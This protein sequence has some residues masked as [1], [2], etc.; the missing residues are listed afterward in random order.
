M[1]KM[2]EIK[3]NEVK[4]IGDIFPALIHYNSNNLIA[5]LIR[6][7]FK[8]NG[9]IAGGF[10]LQLAKLLKPKAGDLELHVHNV[11]CVNGQNHMTRYFGRTYDHTNNSIFANASSGDI[12]LWFPDKQSLASFE[13]SDELKELL[14]LRYE[15]QPKTFHTKLTSTG[16]AKQYAIDHSIRVQVITAYLLPKIEQ[17]SRFDIYNS[18]CAFDGTTLTYPEHLMDLEDRRML[19]VSNWRSQNS[20]YKSSWTVNRVLKYMNPRHGY[21]AL[22]PETAETLS[23]LLLDACDNIKNI[24]LANKVKSTTDESQLFS[25]AVSDTTAITNKNP[26]A[27]E[28]FIDSCVRE[29][30]TYKLLKTLNRISKSVTSDKLLMIASLHIEDDNYVCLAKDVLMSRLKL[31]ANKAIFT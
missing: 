24:Q 7:A 8:H 4:V 19:H 17:I 1:T 9:Y 27:N 14:N 15:T 30:L 31:G 3:F 12:D 16:T 21:N 13:S 20:T 5:D 29:L 11:T 28:K 25:Q 10:A 6:L 2:T 23:N 18:M 22:T 26:H